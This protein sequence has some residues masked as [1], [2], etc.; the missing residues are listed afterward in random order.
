MTRFE[1]IRPTASNSMLSSVTAVEPISRR[2]LG[3][4]GTMRMADAQHVL[5]NWGPK[6]TVKLHTRRR[7]SAAARRAARTFVLPK[8]SRWGPWL[9]AGISLALAGALVS[10][11]L[12]WG[13]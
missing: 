9:A 5:E 12:A 4:R 11:V 8:P 2:D 13:M 3:P 1:D 10:V 7:P 6:G